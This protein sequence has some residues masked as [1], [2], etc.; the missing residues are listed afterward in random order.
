MRRE[1]DFIGGQEKMRASK[2]MKRWEKTR[3][4]GRT[5][6]VWLNSVVGWGIPVGLFWAV[7]MM[8]WEEGFVFSEW[9]LRSFLISLGVAIVF[10]PLT[11]YFGGISSWNV[12]E[13][14]YLDAKKK[15]EKT[16]SLTT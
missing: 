5:R 16:R 12:M 10:F 3:S 6:F 1:N 7:W 14:K 9:S 2:W 15:I 8:F 11:G 13:K 4:R